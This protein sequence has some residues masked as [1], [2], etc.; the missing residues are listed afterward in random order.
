MQ[1]KI[2]KII[3]ECSSNID[4]GMSRDI[5][6]FLDDNEEVANYTIN[7]NDEKKILIHI[8][9]TDYNS[10]S[11]KKNWSRFVDFVGYGYLNLYVKEQLQDQIKYIYFTAN[12]NMLGTKMEVLIG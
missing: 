1:T 6:A 11:A 2:I 4:V 3:E 8:Q 12:H 5:R 7:T 9:L 10:I